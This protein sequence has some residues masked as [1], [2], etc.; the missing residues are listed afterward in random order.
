MTTTDTLEQ[1]DAIL[2]S[3]READS[4]SSYTANLFAG[5]ASDI[6]AKI[7]EETG[8][9]AEA[10]QLDDDGHLAREV[11]DLWFHCMVLLQSRGLDSQAVLAVLAERLGM[12]G[13]DEKA[14]R[15]N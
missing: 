6:V 8:E 2:A 1:L 4:G 9:V 7:E 5:G 13:L 10:A 11:A 15:T 3:R 12:S 14:A